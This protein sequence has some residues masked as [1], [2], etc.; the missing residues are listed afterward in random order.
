MEV[1]LDR[2]RLYEDAGRPRRDA[3][4]TWMEL[5]D[6]AVIIFD[7]SALESPWVK[8]ETAILTWRLSRDP[9]FVLIPLVVSPVNF[10]A[11]RGKDFSASGYG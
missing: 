4:N 8:Q 5:C 2:T 10:E 11:L 9:Q 7:E 3:L 6:A 1:L